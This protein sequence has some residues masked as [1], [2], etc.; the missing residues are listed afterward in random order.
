MYDADVYIRPRASWKPC[1]GRI[2][3]SRVSPEVKTQQGLCVVCVPQQVYM[4]MKVYAQFLFLVLTISLIRTNVC[5][6]LFEKIV[7]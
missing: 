5:C 3:T 1:L 4:H 7:L 2:Y 6:N